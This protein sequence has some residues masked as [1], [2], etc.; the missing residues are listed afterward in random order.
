MRKSRSR[1]SES[2]YAVSRSPPLAC[3]ALAPPLRDVMRGPP[4]DTHY[5]RDALTSA[6]RKCRTVRSCVRHRPRSGRLNCIRSGVP[7]GLRSRQT[8]SNFYCFVQAD[9]G[10][11][12]QVAVSTLAPTATISP[13][14]GPD[15]EPHQL[16]S[17]VTLYPLVSRS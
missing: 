12:N 3:P 17:A 5:G 16:F 4:R 11:A 8:F 1:H 13:G 6:N 10:C 7:R 15:G 2:P 14:T 9:A